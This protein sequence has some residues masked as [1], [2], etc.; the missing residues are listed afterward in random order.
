MRVS[1]FFEV[2]VFVVL[3]VVITVVLSENEKTT[4]MCS[5][6]EATYIATFARWSDFGHPSGHC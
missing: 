3:T 1:K 2:V 4:R 6:N 5:R